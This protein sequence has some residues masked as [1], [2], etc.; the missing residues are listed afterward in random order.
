MMRN[1]SK[2]QFGGESTAG[3]VS[4]DGFAYFQPGETRIEEYDDR[5]TCSAERHAEDALLAGQLLQAREQRAERSAVGLMDAVFERR[6][7]QL[8]PSLHEGG[9]Q[10]H[11]ILDVR[12]GVGSGILR[13]KNTASI[14][15]GQSFVGNG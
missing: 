5:W 12:Y 4:C 7:E 13:R 11:G 3:E 1:G 8:V 15:G 9:E 2:E 10:Q 14:F 6:R